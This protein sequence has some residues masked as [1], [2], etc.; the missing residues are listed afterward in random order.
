MAAHARVSPLVLALDVLESVSQKLLV[1]H[2]RKQVSGVLSALELLIDVLV[3]AKLA[4]EA[5]VI[6]SYVLAVW[7]LGELG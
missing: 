1:C 2:Q 3:E 5:Q 7:K 6:V 4:A